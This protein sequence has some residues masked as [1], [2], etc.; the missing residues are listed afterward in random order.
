MSLRLIDGAGV[1]SA[2]SVIDI[3]GGS[4]RLVDALLARGYRDLTV[5]DISDA[6]LQVAKDR[7]GPK[8]A[9]VQ[10]IGR[11]IVAL[12]PTRRYGLWHDRAVLHFLTSEADQ[13]HYVDTLRAAT[14]PS[15]VAVFGCFAP[16]GPRQCSGLPVVRRSAADLANLLGRDW[17][18]VADA[19]EQHPTPDGHSQPFTWATFI[20]NDTTT[21]S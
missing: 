1:T 6:A 3:G 21:T 4:S 18:L 16:D 10:W 20:R 5:L 19:H 15:S 7:L 14:G 12:A 8:A 11:D 17:T 9:R 2:T 13:T